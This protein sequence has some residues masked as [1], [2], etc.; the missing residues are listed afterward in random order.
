MSLTLLLTLSTKQMLQYEDT[1]Q[2]IE[3][4]ERRADESFYPETPV[5]QKASRKR[6]IKATRKQIQKDQQTKKQQ[7]SPDVSEMVE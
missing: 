6:A 7:R 2:A 4:E 5:K 3:D 1:L